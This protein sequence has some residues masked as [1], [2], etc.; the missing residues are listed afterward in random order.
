MGTISNHPKVN[1]SKKRTFCEAVKLDLKETF[2]PDNPFGGFES[3]PPGRRFWYG[4]QYFVPILEWGP[5]YTLSYFQSDLLAGLTIAS[6]A[7]PQG[8]SYARLAALPP[9]IGLCKDMS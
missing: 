7:I 5:K 4:L 1:L 2:F 9:I 8:I 3:F 6:L